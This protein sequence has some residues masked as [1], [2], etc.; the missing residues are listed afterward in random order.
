MNLGTLEEPNLVKIAKD[1]G[2]YKEKVQDLLIQ[3]RDMFTL[4]YK[5]MKRIPPYVCKH[6]M[7]LQP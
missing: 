4:T 5:D 1:L 6:K 7:E 2:E 3:F